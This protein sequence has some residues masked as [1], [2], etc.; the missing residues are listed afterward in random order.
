[1]SNLAGRVAVVTG[2]SRGIGRAIALELARR[3]AAVVINYNRSAEA[4]EQVV[5]AIQSAGG[6]ALAVQADVSQAAQAEALIRAAQT[7]FGKLDI[8]VNNAGVT[9][10]GLLLS[11]KEEDWDSVLT[12]N[13]KSAWSCSKAAVRGM[14]R[15]RSGRIVNI[16]SVVGI[17]GQAG[18]TNYSASKAGLIGF[19]KALAREVASRGITVNAVAP[20]FI[21]TDMTANLSAELMAEIR[22]RIPLA[23]YGT[24]EDVAYAVAFL[25]SDEAS[26]ITGQVLTIDG[27]L[28][29]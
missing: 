4:A 15:Q 17:S 5:A 2:A 16:T 19:T 26:Y 3:G 22:E 14:I 21:T 18:Q 23:R 8:L 28:I 6:R 27:G 20:G 11:M 24:P 10:D 25:V 13:L 7:Q 12:T 29:M 9:R 1:M